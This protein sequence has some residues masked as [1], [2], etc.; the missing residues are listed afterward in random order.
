M[1][2]AR[3]DE[4]GLGDPVRYLRP[5]RW[6]CGPTSP[7]PG[8]PAEGGARSAPHCITD[9]VALAEC[10]ASRRDPDSVRD[11]PTPHN[12]P[13]SPPD[14]TFSSTDRKLI[15]TDNTFSRT[16]QTYSRIDQTFYKTDRHFSST[17]LVT[18]A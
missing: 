16:D 2:S 9:H 8:D 12:P 5:V 3:A 17:A 14:H 1:V 15:R 18:N 11:R 6:P 7:S 4:A 10:K 13:D